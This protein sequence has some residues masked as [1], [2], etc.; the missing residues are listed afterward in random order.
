MVISAAHK[1]GVTKMATFYCA[2]IPACSQAVP[3]FAAVGKQQ[4]VAVPV[5]AAVS[6][7]ATNYVAQCLAAK[8]AGADGMFIA[9]TSDV[10]I[11]V[12]QDCAKQGYTPHLITSSGAY[13]V[14]LL[15]TKGANGMISA[16]TVAPFFDTKVPAIKIMTAAFNKYEPAVTHSTA[17]NDEAVMQ[18]ATG[19]LIAQG[20]KTGK[21]GTTNPI[22]ATALAN[23][24]H[25]IGS[26]NLDGLTPTLTLSPG[27]AQVNRCFFYA[28]IRNNRFTTPYGLTATCIS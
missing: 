9:A 25:A 18:W 10:E 12:V 5:S 13:G 3:A 22:T 4:D 8:E 11:R 1:I 26:T 28:A 24:L 7:S 17:Y 20:F 27:Q 19:V 2:E 16:E 21:L 15:G 6:S 14:S 23:G